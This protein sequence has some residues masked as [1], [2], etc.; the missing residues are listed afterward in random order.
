MHNIALFGQMASGK[1]TISAALVDAGYVKISFAGPLKA[2]SELA[3]GKIYKSEYYTVIQDGNEVRLS[4]RQILQGV[5]QSVKSL[6]RN[7]WLNCF[8]RTA[9]SFGETSL[10]VDDGRFIFERDALRKAGWTIVGI[11]TAH[12]IRMQRYQTLYG[13]EPTEEEQ[14][15]QSELEIPTILDHADLIV[16]GS[17]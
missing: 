13:R 8:L 12:A 9:R 2:V 5:G 16:Q 1:S 4:G 11:H 15:H 7:F 17:E 3:Y 14:N 6:D 10:V